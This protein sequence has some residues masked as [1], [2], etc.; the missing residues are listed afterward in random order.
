MEGDLLDGEGEAAQGADDVAGG[1]F[2]GGAGELRN[3]VALGLVVADE[4]KGAVGI[5]G[6]NGK[7]GEAVLLHSKVEAGGGDDTQPA[8]AHAAGEGG[9]LGRGEQGVL[10]DVVEED[11]AGGAAVGVGCGVGEGFQMLKDGTTEQ[12]GVG[13]F[14]VVGGEVEGGFPCEFT[15]EREEF[16]R[17]LGTEAPEAGGVAVGPA[18]R[19]GDGE[20]G[21]ALATETVDGGDDAD[22]TGAELVVEFV[23]FIAATDE[24]GVL[25]A[26][27]ARDGQGA[28]GAHEALVEGLAKAG[29]AGADVCFL[30]GEDAFV[31]EGAEVGVVAAHEFGELPGVCMLG[32]AGDFDEVDG[33]DAFAAHELVDLAGDVF[34]PL[35][36]AIL[37]GEVAGGEADEEDA[38][39]AQGAEN[40]QPPVV[41]VFDF[42]RV[43]E[44]AQALRGELRVV[45]DDVVADGG[46]PAGGVVLAGVGDKDVVFGLV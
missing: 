42:Q 46:D 39:F 38:A 13:F 34:F 12:G 16:G 25:P 9:E 5:K 18:V 11:E 7:E 4:E 44:D 41:G 45:G 22:C 40:A 20:F 14:G 30:Q 10:G 33:G 2:F 26:E 15:D 32:A 35:P 17:A 8:S 3:A 24:V 27:V 37:A 6:I 36:D 23:E 29:H 43:E 28:A 1:V 19:V 31:E 21:F